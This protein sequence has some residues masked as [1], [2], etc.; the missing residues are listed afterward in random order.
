MTR[1]ALMTKLV[2]LYRKRDDMVEFDKHYESIHT[3]LVK[4]YPGLRKLEITRITGAPIGESKYHLM[5]EMYFENRE[6]MEAALASKEGKAV[7][8]DL[9][10]FAADIV[11]VFMGESE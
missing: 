8:R 5:A 4:K 1:D 10:G 9:M 6:A 11:T 2:A 7:A 3:P